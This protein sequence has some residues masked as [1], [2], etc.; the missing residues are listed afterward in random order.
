MCVE[1]VKWFAY[2][3]IDECRFKNNSGT[4]AHLVVLLHLLLCNVVSGVEPE[5][6]IRSTLKVKMVH[7]IIS[8]STK[9]M[10]KSKLRVEIKS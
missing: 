8:I 7:S 1:M 10:T 9:I 5:I 6:R 2:P 4:F 3:S